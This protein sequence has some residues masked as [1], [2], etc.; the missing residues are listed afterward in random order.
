MD[1]QIAKII[2]GGE[3]LVDEPLSRHTTWGIGGP[4]DVFVRPAN[5]RELTGLLQ[6]ASENQIPVTVLG[7]GSNCLVSDTGVRGIVISLA[8]T[9]KSIHLDNGDVRAEA[10]VM[11]GHL[12]RRCLQA[13]LTGMEN[14][15]GVPGTLGGALMMNAGAFGEEISSHLVK[16]LVL[17]LEGEE[18]S[19]LR[20]DI[21]FGYRSSSIPPD[22]I[23]LEAEFHFEAGSRPEI[24]ER[25]KQVSIQR[26]ARQP[27]RQRSAGSVFKNPASGLSAGKLIDQA[28]L[29]GTRR[30]DAEISTQHG[31][32][33]IN[34]GTAMADDIAFLIKLAAR[35][36]KQQFDLQLE[37]EIRTLGF[38][39]GFWEDAGLA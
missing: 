31:N 39:P 17:N 5:R 18:K 23:I 19:Y 2:T 20:D 30:G 32:F 26:R 7:S 1:Q 36:I 10:G 33:F 13:G 9:L 37:L 8:G 11:L 28:G 21:Q 22:E 29:K 4:A 35:T 16:V 24:L 25:Y 14:L 3:Y 27:L 15:I 12:V 34:H 6:F 38:E